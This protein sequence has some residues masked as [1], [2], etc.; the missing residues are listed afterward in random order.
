[1]TPSSPG[2]AISPKT[3]LFIDDDSKNREYWL[4]EVKRL[5]PNYTFLEAG[6]GELG[7]RICRDH[8]VDCIV[9][10]LDLLD[11]SGFEVL[12][13]L[14]ADP[15]RKCIPVIVLTRLARP[16]IHELAKDNGAQE[17]LVKNRTSWLALDNAIKTAMN[18]VEPMQ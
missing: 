18:C 4:S 12:L 9:L 5:S 3:V 10:D 7:L 8:K 13:T 11:M 15:T 1:M 14:K 2:T 6:E 17:C 16:P